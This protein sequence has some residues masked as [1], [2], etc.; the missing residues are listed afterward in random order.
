MYFLTQFYQRLNRN[1]KPVIHL[2]LNRCIRDKSSITGKN[3]DSIMNDANPSDFRG[4]SKTIF[5]L[6]P[7]RYKESHKFH[8]LSEEEQW[9]VIMIKDMVELR[10]EKSITRSLDVENDPTLSLEEIKLII[11][12]VCT[13]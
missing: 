1:P 10:R 13:S 5:N 12:D 8:H 2:M 7:K 3:I 9:K 11:H 4:V 6:V